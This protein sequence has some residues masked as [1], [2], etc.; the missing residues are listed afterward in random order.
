MEK[1]SYFIED[2]ALFGSFPTQATVELLEEQGVRFFID[3][4]EDTESKIVPYV[5]KYTYIKYSIP[6]RSY[7]NDWKSFAKLIIRISN[8]I[9]KDEGKIYIHCKGGHGRSG[10]LV[11]CILTHLY[12]ISP[13]EALRRTS[14]FHSKRPIMKEKWRK[15]GSPQSKRQ[16]DFVYKFF[17]P[18]FFYKPCRSSLL[19]G[20][21]N[22]SPHPVEINGEKYPNAYYAFHSLKTP[23]NQVECMYEILENKFLQNENIR[24]NF[25]NT[26][27]R[28]FIKISLDNFWGYGAQGTGKNIQGKLLDRLRLQLLN[29]EINQ[30]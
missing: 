6:D 9:Q 26:G 29:N 16:K 2:K 7:P 22:K 4:T 12:N 25:T 23:T 3:L 15:I 17:R 8:I 28:P 1:C 19:L 5:T 14:F 20:L 10:I 30:N 21:H 13:A 27:L 24:K 18:L 11:A